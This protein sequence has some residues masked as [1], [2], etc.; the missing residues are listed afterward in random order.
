MALPRGRLA[1]RFSRVPLIHRSAE[2]NSLV[3]RID[4]AERAKLIKAE[5]GVYYVTDHYLNHPMV[6]VRL[7]KID[8]KSLKELLDMAWRF[9]NPRS[10]T[11]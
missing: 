6:L 10:K 5:P 1:G 2:P 7:S 3:V 4:R 9:L 8:R 11:A